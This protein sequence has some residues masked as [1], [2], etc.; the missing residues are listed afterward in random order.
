[1]GQDNNE[2]LYQRQ[3]EAMVENQIKG[4]GIT[5]T[6]ILNA[7]RQVPR[8]LFMPSGARESAYQDRPVP[9]GHGQTISQPYIVARMIDQLE[10]RGGEKILE[11]GTGMG[12][13]TAVLAEIGEEVYSVERIPE[14]MKRAEQI[15]ERL[16][17]DNAILKTGDG[18]KGWPEYAPFDRIIVA[19]AAETIPEILKEQLAVDGIMI[20]PVG[21]H[22]FGQQLYRIRR[23][24]EQSFTTETLDYVAFVPLIPDKEG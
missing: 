11:I 24:S 8:H 15:Y 5:D 10:L 19:A 22:Q 16:G 17:I 4:R 1:M 21:R 20:I 3:R 13:Q 14:L 2:Q 12:Y 7:M 6:K 9:I 18:T 23:N